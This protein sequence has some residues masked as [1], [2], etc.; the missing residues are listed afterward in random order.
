MITNESYIVDLANSQDK[1]LKYDFAKEMCFDVK[2]PG[3]EFFR[4]RSLI[5]L[6]KSPDLMISASGFSNT[7]F[8]HLVLTNCATG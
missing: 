6:L 3:D 1:K 5:R 7:N 4:D 8:F 2:A